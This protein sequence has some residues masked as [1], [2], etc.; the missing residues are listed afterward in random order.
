MKIYYSDFIEKT[1]F[2]IITD[3]EVEKLQK[4]IAYLKHQNS[5]NKYNK[6]FDHGSFVPS[7]FELFKSRVVGNYGLPEQITEKY[8]N[9]VIEITEFD[10]KFVNNQTVV[11]VLNKK[12][13][14]SSY[15]RIGKPSTPKTYFLKYRANFL[16][17]LFAAK[18]PEKIIAF[19]HYI[20]CT[21]TNNVAFPKGG[22]SW[23]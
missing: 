22:L 15:I 8:P 5:E 9:E 23:E 20:I 19:L 21:K 13:N 2:I 16:N 1:S 11:L 10:E 17:N 18:S 4:V 7:Y 6:Y 14:Y 12:Q 3:G